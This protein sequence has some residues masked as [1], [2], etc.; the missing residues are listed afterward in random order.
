MIL[1]KMYRSN[2]TDLQM[3]GIS[4][5][6]FGLESTYHLVQDLVQF[7][8]LK[9]HENSLLK[10]LVQLLSDSIKL[11]SVR[12][13]IYPNVSLRF[14]KVL[15]RMGSIAGGPAYFVLH[16]QKGITIC[17]FFFN[18]PGLQNSRFCI[19]SLCCLHVYDKL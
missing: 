3:V 4:F 2:M 10:I 18:L 17:L 7:F 1:K 9:V 16:P 12:A 19:S 6:E 15:N 11:R 14:G 8:D 5:C 13:S